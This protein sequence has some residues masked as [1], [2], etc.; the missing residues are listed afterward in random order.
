M[1]K[2]S[3]QPA[4][5]VNP[6]GDSPKFR[7]RADA[8]P[9]EVLDAALALFTQNGFAKTTVEQV[10]ASAGLSKGAVYLYFPSKK[11]LLEGLVRRAIVPTADQALSVIAGY[12]GDP[13]PVIRKFMTKAASAA[14]GPS[15]FAVPKLV[16]REAVNAPE[17]AQ[18]YRAQVL[19]K[20]IPALTA[21]IAQGV[22]GGHIR[23]VNPELTVRSVIGPLMLHV[24][25][26]EVF[27][28]QP[29][30]GLEL[31]SLID[32]HLGILFAGLEPEAEVKK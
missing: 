1:R 8:R 32:N 29:D 5:A 10:A 26:A 11:A 2:E 20:V 7:R 4:E 15:V 17:I 19:E 28:I 30:N 21:L 6:A 12:R 3:S 9:D 27:A 13:R 14:T 16:M 24:M 31:E 18:M 23:Q 25:L 22:E